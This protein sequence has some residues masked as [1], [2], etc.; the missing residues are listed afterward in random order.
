MIFLFKIENFRNYL[1]YVLFFFSSKITQITFGKWS[2][3][4]CV[5]VFL[6][7]SVTYLHTVG[8]V[9]QSSFKVHIKIEL[10]IQSSHIYTTLPT[11][12]T[13]HHISIL[14]TV[15]EPTLMPRYQ[16]KSHIS[17]YSKCTIYEFQ[18]LST[19]HLW[20]LFFFFFLENS[21]TWKVKDHHHFKI[22][23]KNK[24]K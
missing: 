13:P 20:L 4:A 19:F 3:G 21:C 6:S 11:G 24:N 18:P 7:Y 2:Q 10:K 15:S 9:F 22:L 1:V 8:F 17:V 5:V 16:P 23:I 12:Y 14:V